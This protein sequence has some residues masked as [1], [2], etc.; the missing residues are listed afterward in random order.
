MLATKWPKISHGRVI[1]KE[2]NPEFQFTMLIWKIFSSWNA[3]ISCCVFSVCLSTWWHLCPSVFSSPF[4]P[5]LMLFYSLRGF[6]FTPN[7]W[8]FFGVDSHVNFL[9]RV[10][11]YWLFFQLWIVWFKWYNNVV[12]TWLAIPKWPLTLPWLVNYLS[13]KPG[14]SLW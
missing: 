3:W 10:L 7:I 11:E 1:W 9:I 13:E 14:K 12:E 4:I 6:I 5:Y 8:I 2:N